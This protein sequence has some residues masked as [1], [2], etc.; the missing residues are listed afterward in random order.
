MHFEIYNNHCPIMWRVDYAGDS[1]VTILA[2]TLLS[3][4]RISISLCF[5]LTLSGV[6]FGQPVVTYNRL[7]TIN[8][9]KIVNQHNEVVLFAGNSFLEQ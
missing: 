6:A 5:L 9:N 8:G 4:R 1:Q 2:H 3:I 7:L